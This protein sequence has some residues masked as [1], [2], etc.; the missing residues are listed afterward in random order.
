MMEFIRALAV[1]VNTI[2][3]EPSEENFGDFMVARGL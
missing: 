2:R 1:L 3:E